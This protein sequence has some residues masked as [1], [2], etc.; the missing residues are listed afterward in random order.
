MCYI[1]HLDTQYV[2][3]FEVH[4]LYD[5]VWYSA[6]Y[7]NLCLSLKEYVLTLHPSS[8]SLF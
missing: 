5:A 7:A 8:A 3:H 4:Y 1:T 6:Y 2:Y